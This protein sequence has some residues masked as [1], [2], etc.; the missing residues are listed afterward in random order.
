MIAFYQDNQTVAAVAVRVLCTGLVFSWLKVLKYARSHEDIGPFV[1]ML[2]HMA[3][4]T[5][6]FLFIF[7]DL[8]IPFTV[9]YFVIFSKA[10]EEDP[11][12]P[13]AFSTFGRA[14]SSVFRM[15]V[16]DFDY[17]QLVSH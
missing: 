11:D 14:A 6:R 15:T 12:T 4:D 17:A 5:F 16:V 1:V 9:A 13:G 8:F 7:L 10:E 3:E 2:G